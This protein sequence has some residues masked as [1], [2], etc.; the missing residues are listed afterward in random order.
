[1]KDA[2]AVALAEDTVNKIMS[3]AIAPPTDEGTPVSD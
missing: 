2:G 3:G 1:M